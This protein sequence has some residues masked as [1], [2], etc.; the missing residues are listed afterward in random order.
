[1]RMPRWINETGPE[2]D[3]VIS[4]RVRVARNIAELPFP[5]LVDEKTGKEILEQVYHAVIEGNSNLKEMFQLVEMRGLDIIER[6]SYIEKHLLSPDLAKKVAIGGM[7]INQE[8]TISI[9]IN[10]EDHIRIQCLLPG[11]Q[12][13]EAWEMADK[14]DDLIEEKVKYAFLEELGYLTSCPSNLGTG[15]R[16]SVMMHLPAMN[17]T[18]YINGVLQASSQIGIAVR[19]IYGEGTEF[20]GNLFQISNQV[21]LGLSE[22]E[23]IKNLKDVSMQIIQKER[24]MREHLLK[25]S[26]LELEDRIFRSYGILKNARIISS[27]EAM[28][29]ISDVK[30][31]VSMELITDVTLEKLNHLMAMIQIGFLQKHFK[32]VLEESER[33]IRRAEIIRTTL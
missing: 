16:A 3:I 18:G 26:R 2:S 20:L 14:I 24:M 6:M 23:V 29:L 5:Q 33:D 8:E 1:M 10:E 25:E 12:L 13:D 27:N 22:E 31:G 15:I 32:R 11:M 7:L 21:T 19:G 28:K 17:M 9:L 4:S 30:L